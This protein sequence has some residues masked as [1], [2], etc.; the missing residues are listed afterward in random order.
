M[1][2]AT[3][4]C[5]KCKSR[6]KFGEERWYKNHPVCV[7]CDRRMKEKRVVDEEDSEDEAPKQ[8]VDDG[9]VDPEEIG[10]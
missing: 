3:V 10:L 9:S 4:I 2:S 8:E 1:A 5:W 7:A 6:V